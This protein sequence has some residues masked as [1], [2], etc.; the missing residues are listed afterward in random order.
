MVLAEPA[1]LEEV[2]VEMALP[3]A[4]GGASSSQPYPNPLNPASTVS[5][6]RSSE[7]LPL[8]GVHLLQKDRSTPRRDQLPVAE[9]SSQY[10]PGEKGGQGRDRSS[11]DAPS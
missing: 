6:N 3:G 4:R 2:R 8:N 10:R 5:I 9:L 1:L 11:A 7:P